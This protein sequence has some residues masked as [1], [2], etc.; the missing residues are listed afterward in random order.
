M[1]SSAIPIQIWWLIMEGKEHYDL[2]TEP[3]STP[4]RQLL[5]SVYYTNYIIIQSQ[6]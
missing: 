3:Q 6:Y 5:P 4:F 1:K 2:Q